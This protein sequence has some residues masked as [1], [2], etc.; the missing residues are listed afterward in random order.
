MMK[1]RNT[2]KVSFDLFY[3]IFLEAGFYMNISVCECLQ[4][5]H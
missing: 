4:E 3:V 1:G 5:N 2:D